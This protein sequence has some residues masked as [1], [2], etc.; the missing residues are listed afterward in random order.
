MRV[1]LDT[2]AVQTAQATVLHADGRGTRRRAV[3]GLFA[4]VGT[5]HP[6]S[7]PDAQVAVG[8]RAGESGRVAE[9]RARVALQVG[10]KHLARLAGSSPVL[11]RIAA[12]KQAQSETDDK[13]Q[14]VGHDYATYYHGRHPCREMAPEHV[15]CH[16]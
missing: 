13:G 12:A 6:A 7:V 9:G 15:Y 11:G 5:G 14:T 3:A 2:R 4:A 16:D 1:R 8:A 10:A